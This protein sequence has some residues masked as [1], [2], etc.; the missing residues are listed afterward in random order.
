MI[1]WQTICLSKFSFLANNNFFICYKSFFAIKTC[2]FLCFNS[3]SL[4]FCITHFPDAKQAWDIILSYTFLKRLP[5]MQQM[6]GITSDSTRH[7]KWNKNCIKWVLYK[8]NQMETMVC[9]N[10]IIRRPRINLV[11]NARMGMVN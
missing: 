11:Q 1:R 7:I 2:C 9:W 5:S 3:L 4:L 6:E 8:T 10:S